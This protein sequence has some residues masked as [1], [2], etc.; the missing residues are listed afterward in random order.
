MFKSGTLRDILKVFEKLRLLKVGKII[1][2]L[3]SYCEI[4]PWVNIIES[5][6]LTKRDTNFA[7][8]VNLVFFTNTLLRKALNK[9]TLIAICWWTGQFVL[10]IFLHL[11][12]AFTSSSMYHG[13]RKRQKNK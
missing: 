1:W 11:A 4:S 2:L 3:G 7:F 10:G 9:K 5:L 12:T 13:C 6:M 8:V